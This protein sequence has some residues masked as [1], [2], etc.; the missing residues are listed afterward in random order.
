MGDL[1]LIKEKQAPSPL[2]G[3][4]PAWGAPWLGQSPCTISAPS[5]ATTAGTLCPCGIALLLAGMGI[6]EKGDLVPWWE[7]GSRPW[8]CTCSAFGLPFKL[9]TP[10]P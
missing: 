5:N 1:H 8:A 2:Q 10:L 9:R 7:R 6:W 4:L 3:E